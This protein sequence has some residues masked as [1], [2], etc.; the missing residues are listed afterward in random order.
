MSIIYNQADFLNKNLPTTDM[1]YR[2]LN[3]LYINI[4]NYVNSNIEDVNNINNDMLKALDETALLYKN[5]IRTVGSVTNSIA[6]VFVTGGGS[7]DSINIFDKD[8]KVVNNGVVIDYDTMQ[9]YLDRKQSIAY[10]LNKISINT[11]S[12]ALGNTIDEKRTY[13]NINNIVSLISR[14][15]IESYESELDIDIDIDMGSDSVFNNI[16]FNLYDFGTRLPV[17]GYIS[18]SKDGCEYE[19]LNISTSN[20]VS[21]D[22]NDFDFENGAINIHVKESSA[23]YIRLNFIQKM[24][25]NTGKTRRRRYAI[26]LNGLEVGFY[27]AVDSGDITIGPMRSK[28][29]IFKV[30][31]YSNM[32]GYD[33]NTENINLSLST[34]QVTWIPFQNSSVFNPDSELSK[35]INFNNIDT[36]S[37]F[38]E[39]KVTVIYLK[40][41]MLSSDVS[42][43]SSSSRR[44]SRQ[45]INASSAS[46]T[47]P[48]E[49]VTSK[50]YIELFNYTDVKYGTRFSIP[51]ALANLNPSMTRNI[52]Y[53][54]RNGITMIQGIGIESD[55]IYNLEKAT[56]EGASENQSI[57]QFK[58]DKI[59]VVRNDI[60]E[61]IPTD[62][63]D[64]F[65]I[66]LCG[67]S[68]IINEPTSIETTDREFK[69]ENYMPVIPYKNN[70]G[71][72]VLR[73]GNRSISITYDH[74]FFLD[75]RETLYAIR[76]DIDSIL[77]EDELGQKIAEIDT[78]IIGDVKYISILDALEEDMPDLN[79][80]GSGNNNSLVFNKRYPLEELGNNEYAIEFGKLVFS[81]Y[82]K[83]VISYSKVFISEIETELDN[84]IGNTRLISKTSK[85]IKTKYQL[86]NYDLKNTIK[87]KHTNILEQSAYFDI[88]KS[89]INAFIKEVQFIDG[90]KEFEIVKSFIQTGNRN[91]N[92]IPLHPDYI[93][94]SSI[95]LRACST[96]FQRRVYNRD[97]L[98]DVG[99]YFIDK[100]TEMAWNS[101]TMTTNSIKLPE[102]ILTSNS[103]DT[104]VGYNIIPE[105][106]SSSGF[107]SIDY[108]RGILHT[109][110]KIDGRTYIGYQYSSVYAKY[111]SLIKVDKED[112]SIAGSSLT[113]NIDDEN[114]SKYLLISS[115]QNEQQVDYME[116]PLL[117]DFNLNIIDASNSI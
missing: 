40:I 12:G 4:S 93:D 80:T 6:D 22:I 86:L 54:E 90:N 43:L 64:P 26:G 21:M 18:I 97:E 39:E 29:E 17:I 52:S 38:T 27:S 70:N 102:G 47:F 116:T 46:R 106:K 49:S 58:Y 91:K 98:I 103:N 101:T 31:A 42:H 75:N 41:S 60:I 56:F 50:D 100:I 66:K 36:S 20:S 44:I 78:F 117:L 104:E 51:Y 48:I 77:V 11:R 69:E 59:H 68:S 94:D 113:I 83:G 13:F 74:G 88:T 7:R 61:N 72:Y 24:S 105:K 114:I 55:D 107:Y 89:S 87:L 84:S 57:I 82:L 45:I 3:L 62:G 33:I 5:T 67:F 73:Y 53:V 34:D 115:H 14:L 28:D 92:T 109:A 25:Y 63:Y 71:L 76:D 111:P 16:K 96:V 35:I 95:E 108:T 65:A 79:V 110:S 23:R 10:S 8:V 30:A 19:K 9:V 2:Y 81:D 85:Q 99:D 15:E 1:G 37:L 112:Y 32:L